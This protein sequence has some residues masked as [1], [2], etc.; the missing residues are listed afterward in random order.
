MRCRNEV[1]RS[2]SF[3]AQAKNLS[4]E[5]LITLKTESVQSC[6]CEISR[7]ARDDN[8]S[9]KCHP[10]SKSLQLRERESDRHSPTA[11]PTQRVPTIFRPT[12]FLKTEMDRSDR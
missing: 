1:R 4:Y 5:A 8:L 12:N 2:L 9:H 10:F 6:F 11:C 7:S 3:G